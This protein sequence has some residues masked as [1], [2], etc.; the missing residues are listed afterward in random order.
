MSATPLPRSIQSSIYGNYKI[1]KI[2]TKPKGRLSV[3][4]KIIQNQLSVNKL[5]THIENESKEGRASLIVAPSIAAG[6]MASIRKIEQICNERFEFSFFKSIHGQL[7]EKEIEKNIESFKRGEF[8]LLI[9]TSMVEAGF[10]YENL[11]TVVITDP[12]RFGISQLHQIRGR[13]GR[14][15][16][17]QGYCALWN[18]T[19]KYNT[20]V[21]DRLT[22]FCR[23][24]DGFMLANNDMLNRGSGDLIGKAQSGGEINFIEYADDVE[25]ILKE[26]DSKV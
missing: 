19:L 20:K 7:T 22:Y 25:L 18:L 1:I 4:T 9:A 10:S 13:T 12:E 23:E 5:L 14:K 26:I 21:Y 3:L 15:A 8:P 24:F 2:A 6:E 16:G 17:L 11:S